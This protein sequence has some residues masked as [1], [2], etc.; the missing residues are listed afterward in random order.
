[1]VQAALDGSPAAAGY[2]SGEI[3]QLEDRLRERI[4]RLNLSVLRKGLELLEA[5]MIDAF[6][7]Y[8]GLVFWISV[9]AGAACL[10]A[11]NASDRSVRR[12]HYTQDAQ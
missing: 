9:V 3:G 8:T 1:M 11:A 7:W 12:R 2:A 10:L 6:L 4:E 5:P